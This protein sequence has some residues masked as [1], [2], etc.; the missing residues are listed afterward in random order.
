MHGPYGCEVQLRPIVERGGDSST[1]GTIVM[2]AI[3]SI[4]NRHA[5]RTA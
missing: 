2:L 4:G 1:L 3:R 5:I